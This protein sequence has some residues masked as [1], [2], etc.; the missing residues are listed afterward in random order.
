MEETERRRRGAHVSARGWL[1]RTL[2]TGAAIVSL[3]LPGVALADDH[4]GGNG[5]GRGGEAEEAV[6]GK[7]TISVRPSTLTDHECDAGEWHFIINRLDEGQAPTEISVSFGGAAQSIPLDKA[8]PG[9][10]AHYSTEDNLDK[11]V[12]AATAAID[13]A[14]DGNFNL[15]HGPCAS[16]VLGTSDETNDGDSKTPAAL[17]AVSAKALTDYECVA[18]EWHFVINQV[19]WTLENAPQIAVSFEGVA[20]PVTLSASKISG[21]VAHYA[22]DQYLTS[23]VLGAVV[24][25][26]DP[27]KIGNFNLS[28]GPCPSGVLGTTD[29]TTGGNTDQTNS[30][31][32]GDESG[33]TVVTSPPPALTLPSSGT[34]VNAGSLSQHPCIP[35][36]LH[37]VIN[38]A[39]WTEQ[40]APRIYV[41]FAGGT[42]VEV[43]STKVTD[44]TAH[45]YITDPALLQL[46]VTGAVAA[47]TDPTW[48][49]SFNLSHGPCF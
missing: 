23:K 7:R 28:H 30:E 32:G 13:G 20:N 1:Y 26:A 6:T 48:N 27:E 18:G 43:A 14:W 38:Q 5:R 15:S 34:L 11:S 17:V 35:G 44:G 37:F 36:E 33:G 24:N 9:G 22:T 39:S 21:G 47:F 46:P 19:D 25:V 49:G 16:G 10:V 4:S 29:T 41:Q 12:T 31:T 3:A 2:A 42:V 40:S 8:T 45:Y